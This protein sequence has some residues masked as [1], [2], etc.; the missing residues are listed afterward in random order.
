MIKVMIV[1]DHQV[2]R[3]GLRA[4]M[5]AQS[6]LETCGEAADGESAVPLVRDAEPDVVIIDLSMPGM[7]GVEATRAILAERPTTRV[8][9]LSWHADGDHV[10]AAMSAGATGYLLKGDESQRLVDAVRAVHRGEDRMSEGLAQH[11]VS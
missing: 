2:V 6:D 7:G 5:D 9:V 8:L 11:I 1:D 10:R 3:L 4:I